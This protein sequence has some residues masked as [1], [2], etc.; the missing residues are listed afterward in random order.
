MSDG[1][2]TLRPGP[3]SDRPMMVSV[4]VVG[5]IVRD[6]MREVVREETPQIVREETSSIRTT[7]AHMNDRMIRNEAKADANHEETTKRLDEHDTLH[8]EHRE[9]FAVLRRDRSAWTAMAVGMGIVNLL[10]QIVDKL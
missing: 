3:D 5:G 10:W 9:M 1:P 4:D 8:Q 2:D 7:L 6:V